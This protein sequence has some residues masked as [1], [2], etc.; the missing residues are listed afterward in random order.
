MTIQKKTLL[1]SRAVT[2]KALI[3][4]NPVSSAPK[5]AIAAPHAAKVQFAAKAAPASAAPKALK[6]PQASKAYAT[7]KALKAPQASKAY[8]TPKALKSAY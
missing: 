4:R 8:A 2:K 3:A 5:T 7:P 6:A 1:N